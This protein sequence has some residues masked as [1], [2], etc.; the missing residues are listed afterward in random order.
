MIG[1][2]PSKKMRPNALPVL[3]RPDNKVEVVDLA[4]KDV[5]TGIASTQGLNM[6]REKVA[7]FRINMLS[8][9][10]KLEIFY[11]NCQVRSLGALICIL[12]AVLKEDPLTWL[13]TG[14]RI[15]TLASSSD[16]QI[17]DVTGYSHPSE[18]PPTCARVRLM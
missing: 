9:G 3:I 18:Q 10:I 1:H 12:M 11:W 13:S 4:K 16:C 6:T 15:G 17:P 7:P 14:N 8:L 2:F 5:I